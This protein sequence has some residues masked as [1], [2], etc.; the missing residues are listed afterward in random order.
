MSYLFGDSTQSPFRINFIEFLRLAIGFGVHVLKAEERVREERARRAKYEQGAEAEKRSLEQ[1]LGRLSEILKDGSAGAESRLSRC[2]KEIQE[3]AQQVLEAQLAGLQVE[4]TQDLAQMEQRIREERKGSFVA[5]EKVILQYDLP[6][7]E[8]TMHL[9]F[10]GMR[11][12]ASL[13]G[14]T[15]YGLNTLVELVLPPESPFHHDARV[16]RFI[17]GLEIHAPETAGW[18]RKESR[19]TPHKLGRYQLLEVRIG[20]SDSLIKLRASM[21]AHAPGYDI[22]FHA[23]EPRI[24]LTKV[25]NKEGDGSGPFEPEA[26]D[27]PNLARFR[28]KLLEAMRPLVMSRRALKG[29]RVAGHNFQEHDGLRT[30]VEQFIQVLAPSVRELAAHSQSREELVLRRMTGEDRR[31]EIFV[32]KSELRGKVADLGADDRRLFAPLGLDDSANGVTSGNLPRRREQAEPVIV[33]E[34]QPPVT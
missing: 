25:G 30:L 22:V 21:E 16:E 29:A 32:S 27:V 19:M 18:I 13:E 11:C 7:A 28:E 15:P 34:D 23:E 3:R 24:Q 12:E 2:A 17:D 20:E 10:E 31:E 1:L 33:I 6:Q 5:L 14:A 8:N 26:M 9:R 4:L